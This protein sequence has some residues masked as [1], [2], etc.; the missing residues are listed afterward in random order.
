M[1]DLSMG[2]LTGS[3]NLSLMA[4]LKRNRDAIS[5]GDPTGDGF[6]RGPNKEAVQA[7]LGMKDKKRKEKTLIQ[8]FL[9]F[10]RAY[11]RD[12]I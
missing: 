8:S 6:D 2:E 1:P 4:R 11:G 7:E 10:L 5:A 9:D 3:S 12:E